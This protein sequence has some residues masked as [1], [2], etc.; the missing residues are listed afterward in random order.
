[1]KLTEIGQRLGLENLTPVTDK[2]VDG[3]YLSDMISDV[4]ANAK[5]GNLLVTGQVH[6]NVVAAANLVD[7]CGVVIAK[8]K[9][10]TEE[11]LQMAAKASITIFSTEMDRWEIASKLYETGIR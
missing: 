7:V 10:P 3:V 2:D 11:V 9:R 5:P 6:A 1:M 8:G 4:V